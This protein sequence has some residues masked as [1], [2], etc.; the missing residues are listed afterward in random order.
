MQR[1]PY[2]RRQLGI[3]P[4]LLAAVLYPYL[5]SP[6]GLYAQITDLSRALVKAW[7]PSQG[8]LEEAV[9]GILESPDGLVWIATRDGVLRFDGVNFQRVARGDELD[10]RDFAV[11]AIAFLGNRVWLGARD[12]ILAAHPDRFGSYI[13]AKFQVRRFSRHED[14][15]F[16]IASFQIAPDGSLM[17]RRADGIFRIPMHTSQ[18]T[19]PPPELV[20][21]APP[22]E[23]IQAW[24]LDSQGHHWISTGQHVYRSQN[25]SWTRVNAAPRNVISILESRQRHIYF[26][27]REGLH[28]YQDGHI[29]KIDLDGLHNVEPGRGILEDRSGAIWVATLGGITRIRDG[30]I[31]ERKLG[32]YMPPDDLMLTLYESSDG[33]IWGGTRWGFLVR[34][35]ESPFQIV[36]RRDGLKQSAV[37]AVA[38]DAQGRHWIATR[39]GGVYLKQKSSWQAVAETQNAIFYALAP[40]GANQMLMAS[41]L[42]LSLSN[43]A[44]TQ[45]LLAS[46]HA[47]STA[48]YHS[49]S[50]P[51]L[52]SHGSTVVFY[53]DSAK[54][55]RIQLTPNGKVT[56]IDPVTNYRLV[57]A[58]L[59]LED[60]LWMLSW[61]DGLARWVAGKLIRFGLGPGPIRRGMG[62]WEVDPHHLLVGT[63]EGARF[64]HRQQLHFT[65][66]PAVFPEE[67]IFQVQEGPNETLW[68]LARRSLLATSRAALER[69]LAGASSEIPV[70]RYTPRSGLPSANFGLGTSALSLLDRNGSLWLA[71]LGGAI[72][73]R[74][75]TIRPKS[76]PLRC[77]ILGL[78]ANGAPVS[79]NQQLQ[80]PPGTNRVQI[81][82]TTTGLWTGEDP[83]IHHQLEGSSVG[84]MDTG[85]NEAVYTNLGPGHYRFRISASLPDQSQASP[86]TVLDFEI[87]PFLYQTPAFRISAS[88]LLAFAFAGGLWLRRRQTVLRTRELEQ[89]V[90]E[91]TAELATARQEAE[92]A[93]ARAEE[94]ARAKSD[95]L[96]TMSHEIRTPMNGVIGMIQLLESTPLGKQHHEQ[97]QVIRSCGELLLAIVNDLLDLSKIETGSLQLEKVTFAL[98]PLLE[99]CA[100]LF[101]PQAVQKGLRFSL[102][103][104]SDIPAFVLGDPVR[105]RQIILNLVGNSIKFTESGSISLT[106]SRELPSSAHPGIRI[107]V[108]DT[109]IG[110]PGDKLPEIFK[111]FTQAESSTTRR[112]GGTGLGLAICDRLVRAMGG[113]I[114]VTS[115]F[116]QGSE[117]TVVLPLEESSPTHLIPDEKV[118]TAPPQLGL[119]VLVVEDNAVNRRITEGLL[120]KLGCQVTSVEDGILAVETVAR[121]RFDVIFMD[122]H[123][124]RMDGYEAAQRIRQLNGWAATV[125]IIALTASVASEDRQKSRQA[126]MTDHL[127]K[128]VTLADLRNVLVKIALA[129]TKQ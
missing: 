1:T 20:L 107:V 100:A 8:M 110:I 69:F 34:L 99:E 35:E 71:S 95:F 3:R 89:R 98:K 16:G 103:L 53:S 93:R 87:A 125:P 54:I 61:E 32:T 48:R 52:D 36:N 122:C 117:F 41:N 60:G 13:H 15:R 55:W 79:L 78:R 56:S 22:G 82:F 26:L 77:L 112:Y 6:L 42:G 105:I 67:H 116:G 7:G 51:Q 83:V 66:H 81:Q 92:Q 85:S 65:P 113:S 68:F 128:P 119:H 43:G 27:G 38:Q 9:F 109:G 58:I 94:A 74:P 30:R 104:S 127:V 23:S 57:R 44:Q 91:R 29:Q 88:V 19:I 11:G 80:L 25:H 118:S 90:A 24:I 129:S 97:L 126:G 72:H 121:A 4:V 106:V 46:P 96:A 114:S 63:S 33:A 45:L 31:E 70:R 75:E 64:F 84:R 108:R 115:T 101:Q 120:A 40:V 59:P 17:L 2:Q 73:F 47:D 86:E 49:F 111:A 62:L 5:L 76:R 50:Q 37:S 12:S 124:P 14:D 102:Y 10:A 39:A 123:M 18:N 21:A 28:R